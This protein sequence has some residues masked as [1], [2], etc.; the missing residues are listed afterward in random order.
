MF[1]LFDA[2]HKWIK[3]EEASLKFG[4]HIKLVQELR[5]NT[6]LKQMDRII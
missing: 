4:Q 6:P 5:Q 3:A 2:M 1:D